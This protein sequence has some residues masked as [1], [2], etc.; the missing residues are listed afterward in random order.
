LFADPNKARFYAEVAAQGGKV[1]HLSPAIGTEVT[2]ASLKKLSPEARDDLALLVAERGVVGE[3]GV[4]YV[5]EVTPP[6]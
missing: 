4:P 5:H 6:R 3:L 2:G 1:K